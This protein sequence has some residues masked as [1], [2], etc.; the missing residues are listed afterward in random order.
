[1]LVIRLDL[2]GA[3]E[4]HDRSRRRR[5]RYCYPN[6][7]SAQE[8]PISPVGIYENLPCTVRGRPGHLAARYFY[9]HCSLTPLFLHQ[10]TEETLTDQQYSALVAQHGFSR[11]LE[12]VPAPGTVHVRVLVRDNARG[13]MRSVELLYRIEKSADT[14]KT[15]CERPGP[16][17]ARK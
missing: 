13:R 1:M 12:F 8:T 9:P 6:S 16:G 17:D 7:R 11:T 15:G 4:I 3:G 14:A 2:L 5:V 10:P